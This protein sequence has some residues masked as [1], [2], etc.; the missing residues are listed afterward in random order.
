MCVMRLSKILWLN[1]LSSGCMKCSC[2]RSIALFSEVTQ[3][4]PPEGDWDELSQQR[5]HSLDFLILNYVYRKY[6]K[7]RKL[8][9]DVTISTFC[10]LPGLAQHPY[11]FAQ[12]S[13]TLIISVEYVCCQN[14]KCRWLSYSHFL[15]CS[16]LWRVRDRLLHTYWL[17]DWYPVAPLP[18]L[19]LCHIILMYSEW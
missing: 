6:W 8:L 9:Y 11:I 5:L 12:I 7:A 13:H 15:Y 1:C 2:L 18:F 17:I 10:Y 19:S 16:K 14:L 4:W 3:M